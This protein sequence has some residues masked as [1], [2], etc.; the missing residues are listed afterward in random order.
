[1]SCFGDESIH[2]VA[3]NYDSEQKVAFFVF[4]TKVSHAVRNDSWHAWSL[5]EE[6][7][8]IGLLELVYFGFVDDS[9]ESVQESSVMHLN[10]DLFRL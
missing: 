1:M 3:H 5:V 7:F 2:L 8:F 6:K 9:N 10:E 4:N